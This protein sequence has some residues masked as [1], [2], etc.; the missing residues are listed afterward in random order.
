M[1][2]MLK[3]FSAI[4][5]ALVLFAT[6]RADFR[7]WTS[8]D[9]Q[10]QIEAE[11]VGMKSPEVVV[12]KQ[13][14][15]SLLIDVQ[16]VRLSAAD[17]TYVRGLN[18]TLPAATAPQATPP[19]APPVDASVEPMN[20]EETDRALRAVER[21]ANAAKTAEEAVVLYSVFIAEPS[22]PPAGREVAQA[23]LAAWKEMADKGLVRLGTRWVT[24]DEAKAARLKADYMIKESLELIKVSQDKLAYEKLQDAAT[25]NYNDITADF[26]LGLAYACHS[27]DFSKADAHFRRCL[28][29][30]PNNPAVLNNLALVQIRLGLPD[31]SIVYWRQAAAV[32][33][34]ERIVQ[35]IA[36]IFDLAGKR[37]L[38]RTVSENALRQLSEVYSSL[39]V[40]KDVRPTISDSGWQY[41]VLP[42]RPPVD[43]SEVELPSD[44]SVTSTMEVCADGIVVAPGYV[45]T[46][47]RATAG[48]S[49]FLITDSGAKGEKFS[50]ALVASSK[51]Y[52][53][54]LLHCPRLRAPP[55]RFD[56]Q[57]PRVGTRIIFGGYPLVDTMATS[58]KTETGAVRSSVV[59]VGRYDAVSYESS[60]PPAVV[61]GPVVDAFGNVLAM[62][63]RNPSL[64][65]NQ[66]CIGIPADVFVPFVQSAVPGRTGDAP[67][68]VDLPRSE[69]DERMRSHTVVVLTQT[70]GQDTGLTTR[71]GDDCFYDPSCC[72]CNGTKVMSCPNPKCIG[73]GIPY[74]VT[75][76]TGINPVTGDRITQTNRRSAPCPVCNRTKSVPCLTCVGTGIDPTAVE[77]A[78][79]MMQKSAATRN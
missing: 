65:G 12:L 50:A 60:N 66:H 78:R 63:W 10:F 33:H 56:L 49:G 4:I 44:P 15:D 27:K 16:L 79:K 36:R 13:K 75:E 55:A 9:G 51:D 48:K 23:K 14:V 25:A 35:N 30:E 64:A 52:D 68:R 47:R 77:G 8:A 42:S 26:L 19:A 62:H 76:I 43:E 41:L 11:F 5:F 2:H 72:K 53:L 67:S 46:T 17:Q 29:R 61:G 34:D 59:N 54:A 74:R 73:G 28:A 71:V 22:L 24:L 32:S 70:A 40:G 31:Q 7:T 18:P 58:M 69:I 20:A 6:A 21:E 3:G 1:N 45:L 57:R 39:V 37:R 38:Q